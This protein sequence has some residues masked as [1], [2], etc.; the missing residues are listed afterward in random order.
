[1]YNYIDNAKE[2]KISNTKIQN[3]L[4]YLSTLQ[5]ITYSIFITQIT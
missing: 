1:M 4:Y 2:R 5:I 3:V